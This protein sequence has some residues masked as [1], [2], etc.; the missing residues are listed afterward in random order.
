M[1]P[2]VSRLARY[3]VA[4]GATAFA[5]ALRAVLAPLLGAKLP[6]VTFWPAILL[7]AWLGG[8][9]P[10]L[11]A[12]LLS[13]MAVSY[14]WLSL[15]HGPDLGD[16]VGLQP[17]TRHHLLGRPRPRPGVSRARSPAPCRS[18]RCPAGAWKS[19]RCV[20]RRP[21][22]QLPPELTAVVVA[23]KGGQRT[24]V[25]M[26]GTSWHRYSWYVRLPGPPE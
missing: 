20:S 4:I 8:F 2:T 23:L 19:L 13:G 12:T 22:V 18:W 5:V 26:L 25:F 6:L 15:P 11:L 17:G 16:A 14:L 10:G 21:D 7:S 24:P 1:P 9:W 3:A